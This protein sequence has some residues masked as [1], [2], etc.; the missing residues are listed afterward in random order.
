MSLSIIKTDQAPAAIGPYSQGI[1]AGPFIFVSG[2]LGLIPETG[3]LAGEEFS[4]QARQALTN[5]SRI[6]KAGGSDLSLVTAVDVYLTDMNDF[7]ELNEIYQEF[8]SDHRP[9]RAAIEVSGLPKNA[10]VEIKC[11]AYRKQ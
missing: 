1:K 8:F 10:L 2:Q 11:I 5:M 7:A 4:I 3:E 9:A 6:I